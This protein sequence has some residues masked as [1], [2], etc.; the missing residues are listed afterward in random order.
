[1]IVHGTLSVFEEV[2]FLYCNIVNYMILRFFVC[3][4]I[5]ISS[6][7]FAQD[8]L[9]IY[10]FIRNEANRGQLE[11]AMSYFN[12]W[13]E[14]EQNLDSLQ[15]VF[16]DSHLKEMRKS[17]FWNSIDDSIRKIYFNQ[18][19]L[20]KERSISYSLWK[21][22][23]EDQKYRTLS[24]Y[25]VFPSPSFGDSIYQNFIA[26]LGAEQAN[27]ERKVYK[28]IKQFGWLDNELVGKHAELA[29]FYIIQHGD[30][31]LQKKCLRLLKK[32]V[33]E[34]TADPYH[35]AMM[36]DRIRKRKGKKQLYGTQLVPK[37]GRIYMSSNKKHT[38]KD[39]WIIYDIKNEKKVNQRRAAL[40]LKP[41]EVDMLEKWGLIYEPISK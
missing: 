37:E 36:S 2:P 41:L 21:M 35:Y 13:I 27:R 40:G 11:K 16:I 4:V 31:K 23:A 1:M 6:F 34:K 9:N 19:P 8:S 14:I 29:C 26:N 12:Q 17:R 22:G 38:I 30:F 10:S 25:F 15:R 18:Y 33:N 32:S 3:V 28:W 24:K 7:S 20:I 39:D 5:F